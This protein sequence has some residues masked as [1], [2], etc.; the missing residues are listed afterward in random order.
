VSEATIAVTGTSIVAQTASDGRYLLNARP[1]ATLVILSIGCKRQITVPPDQA[2]ADAVP[3]PT[4]QAGGGGRRP[5]TGIARQNRP[6]R[7]P[8]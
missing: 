2:T 5:T 6:T 8:Q 3:G 4:L 7:S 1:P